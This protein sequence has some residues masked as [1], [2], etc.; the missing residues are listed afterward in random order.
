MNAVVVDASKA[1]P[2]PKYQKKMKRFVHDHPAAGWG[3]DPFANYGDLVPSIDQAD[4]PTPA[5]VIEIIAHGSP[6]YLHEIG[7]TSVVTFAN[8][9]K[10][11]F[12]GLTDVYLTG[13]N[14]GLSE[15]G[16]CIAEE[17]ARALDG[18][19]V[20]GAAGYVIK[21]AAASADAKTS[22]TDDG[23]AY[24]NS[25]DDKHPT[26]WNHFVFPPSG[27]PGP[28]RVAARSLV[29]PTPEIPADI[30][31]DAI[32]DALRIAA[33]HEQPRFLTGPDVQG[34]IE[35]ADGPFAYEL[36]ARGSI[37][38]NAVTR[39]TWQFPQGP[40]LIDRELRPPR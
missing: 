40:E 15:G 9:L 36:L 28:T 32:S 11:M 34:V 35:L 31:R 12:P 8:G 24:P 23:P 26:C 18:V 4:G 22:R 13:C 30:L 16:Y 17:L 21:G 7:K 3:Y 5:T 10:I 19:T 39:E 38:R 20:Y 25:R 37:L 1:E 6:L 14:T 2:L 27:P 33:P 29:K